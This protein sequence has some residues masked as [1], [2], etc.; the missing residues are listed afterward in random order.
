MTLGEAIEKRNYYLRCLNE[1]VDIIKQSSSTTDTENTERVDSLFSL[2]A[3]HYAMYQKYSLLVSRSESNIK[4]PLADG[5]EVS[6]SDA[7][8]VRESME[9]RY[10]CCRSI[11]DGLQNTGGTV[12]FDIKTVSDMLLKYHDELSNINTT[13]KST[14]WES[15]V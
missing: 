2:L 15:E 7:K 5:V 11:L 14:T 1:V 3:E 9:I 4:L 12:C 13:I 6:I 10:N 8:I